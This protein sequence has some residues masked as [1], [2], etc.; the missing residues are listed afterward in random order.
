MRQNHKQ[1]F[2]KGK[3]KIFNGSVMDLRSKIKDFC[4]VVGMEILDN[5]PHDRLYSESYAEEGGDPELYNYI[6]TV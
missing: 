5:M 6:S 3:I 4:F 2:D 1:L